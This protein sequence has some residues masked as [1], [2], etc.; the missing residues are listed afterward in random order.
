MEDLE[1]VCTRDFFRINMISLKNIEEKFLEIFFFQRQKFVISVFS[2]QKWTSTF[3][4]QSSVSTHFHRANETKL[5]QI[6]RWL[7]WLSWQ[8]ALQ[9]SAIKNRNFITFIII[10]CVQL[11][12]VTN[13][14]DIYFYRVRL[15]FKNH[16]NFRVQISPSHHVLTTH[17]TPW[18]RL[19]I[20][21]RRK[22]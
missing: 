7:C 19:K 17:Q 14:R 1:E 4:F 15:F 11:L 20:N 8:Q 12:F 22:F 9:F 13:P 6:C 2:T 18:F 21:V 16:F 5:V 3:P 10:Y